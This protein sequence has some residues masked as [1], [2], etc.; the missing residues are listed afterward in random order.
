[1]QALPSSV[2]VPGEGRVR[3]DGFR[4][5][6]ASQAA[7]GE[8]L[9]TELSAKLAMIADEGLEHR[10]LSLKGEPVDA[11]VM[12]TAQVAAAGG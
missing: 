5:H 4:S 12:P 3:A 2:R 1:V 11:V 9:V 10:H 8:V 6:L 7:I